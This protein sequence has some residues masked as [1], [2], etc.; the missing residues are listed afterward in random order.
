MSTQTKQE[1]NAHARAR[2][3]RR[4][5]LLS[6]LQLQAQLAFESNGARGL[7]TILS[8]VLELIDEPLNDARRKA[9]VR[10]LEQSSYI[11]E[12]GYRIS[13]ARDEDDRDMLQVEGAISIRDLAQHIVWS[14]RTPTTLE[15]KS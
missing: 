13:I 12:T 3:T 10:V 14:K 8:T 4:R 11:D 15:G 1:K 7:D 6:R 5:V 2:R 9:L